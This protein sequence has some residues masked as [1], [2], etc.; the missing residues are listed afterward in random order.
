[1]RRF[2]LAALIVVGLI[3]PVR[4]ASAQGCDECWEMKKEWR[5]TRT[6]ASAPA[7]V[8]VAAPTSAPTQVTPAP[9]DAAPSLIVIAGAAVVLIYLSVRGRK[10]KAT[11]PD[12]GHPA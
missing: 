6:A 10:A 5:E 9:N 3:A 11:P 12:R 4:L 1:V 2:V 8:A 7:L